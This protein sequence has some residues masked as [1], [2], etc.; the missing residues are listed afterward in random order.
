MKRH[1]G[2]EA[3]RHPS[4]CATSPSRQ[5][6]FVHTLALIWNGRACQAQ[7]IMAAIM[8]DYSH[9]S[10][11][12]EHSS[13][14]AYV[15]SPDNAH[16]RSSLCNFQSSRTISKVNHCLRNS[17]GF[18]C[19]EAL[20]ALRQGNYHGLLD[21]LLFIFNP[22]A[23]ELLVSDFHSFEA[24]IPASNDNFFKMSIYEKK[25]FTKLSYLII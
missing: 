24:G 25:T 9:V 8:A 5:Y 1:F 17:K 20:L 12:S 16:H 6:N 21:I 19:F 23:A 11:P 18:A 10:P 7:F 14:H 15:S 13:M 3:V 2:L 22:C 4:H